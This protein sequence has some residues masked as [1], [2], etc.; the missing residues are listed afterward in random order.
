VPSASGLVA[1]RRAA[2]A[3]WLAY[4]LLLGLLYVRVPPSPDHSVYDYI[5]WVVTRSGTLYVDTAEQNWPG[6]MFLHAASTLLF[7][8]H[9]WSWRL[10]DYGLLLLGC[11][12]LFGF[13]RRSWGEL[14]AWLVV[15]LYQ[16]M[17]VTSG[18]WVAGQRD[19]VAAPLLVAAV[20]ALLRRTAG[21]GRGAAVGYGALLAAAVL[22]RP[23]FALLAPLLGLWDLA[24]ARRAGRSVATVLADHAAAGAGFAGV[25]ASVA[26]LGWPSGALAAWYDASI[27]FNLEVYGPDALS[28]AATA[29][30]LLGYVAGSWH[31]YVALAAAGSALA[32][33]RGRGREVSA[34]L[35][36]LLC[37]FASAVLQRKGFPYH[38]G[39]WLAPLALLMAPVLGVALRDLAAGRRRLV[40]GL[41][42][43]LVVAGLS[44]KVAG[45]LGLEL[46]NLLGR[47]SQHELL[48]AYPAGEPGLSVAQAVEIA[49]Y[50][51]D[52]TREG[53]AVLTWG[54]PILVNHLAERPL[55]MRFTSFALVTLP[56][57][58]FS[59]YDA[60]SAQLRE[61]L[62]EHPPELILLVRK[63][64]GSGYRYLD[65]SEG[66]MGP[67][68]E[69]ALSRYRLERSFG[70][71]DCYRLAR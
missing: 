6:K 26:L 64:D 32:A 10:F 24:W 53:D 18:E 30:R 40:A 17:Y 47:V 56:Q 45:G 34:L 43:L 50:V 55:G 7:G 22:I 39:A 57:P 42:V 60:W 29:A 15:P 4:T 68:V 37:V 67:L 44:K 8:N 46:G 35:A 16:A 52:T 14:E 9:L 2:L 5:G 28:T 58:S 27:R 61:S 23:T 51:R 36:I 62:E 70:P 13:A 21:G 65:P 71:V 66:S 63:P 11:G 41:V 54:R 20:W 19:T 25:L 31:W 59:L 49:D 33:W 1:L 69:Q 12:V 48:A 3:L 38:L